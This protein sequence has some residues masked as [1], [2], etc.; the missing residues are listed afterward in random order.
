MSTATLTTA[1]SDPNMSHGDGGKRFGGK[2]PAGSVRERQVNDFTELAKNVRNAGLME[3]QA[4]WYIRRMIRLGLGF[5]VTAAAFVLIGQS[6]WQLAVA[7]VFAVLGGQ[8]AFLAHDAAHRQ[9]FASGRKNEWA[10]RI[11]GN[12]FVGM[13]YGWWMHK[14]GRHH[15]NPNK[16]GKDGDIKA[17]PIA[18]TPE[19]AAKRT[20]GVAKWVVQH[21]G[22]FFFPLLTLVALG[23]SI[24]SYKRLFSREKV[25]HRYVELAL[26]TIRFAGVPVAAIL[27]LGPTMGLVFAAVQLG[28]LGLYMGASFAPNHKGMPIVPKDVSIDFLRRQTLMSR[29]I[30]GGSLVDWG[31]GGLNFQIEHHLFPSMPSNNLKLVQPMVREYCAE[32]KIKYTETTFLQSHAI[33]VRYLNRVGLGERDPFDCPITA[34]LRSR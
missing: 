24:D 12:L 31:M 3:R 34:Q 2:R 25:S 10:G 19:D 22:W 26:L 30:S 32:K 16:I 4:G 27:Y 33:V 28:V 6:W 29:N 20:K 14:H 5:A 15:A 21:Q 8:A 13:S 23:L 1:P 9:I 18:F 11:V 7:V 17:G